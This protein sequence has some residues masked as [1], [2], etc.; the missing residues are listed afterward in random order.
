MRLYD[1]VRNTLLKSY[2]SKYWMYCYHSIRDVFGV[3]L[4][5]NRSLRFS[6]R[7][8]HKLIIRIHR[9]SKQAYIG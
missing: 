3:S 2:I 6:M 8:H 7:T 4:V 1:N 9:I 5:V